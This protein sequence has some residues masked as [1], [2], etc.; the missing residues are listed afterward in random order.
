MVRRDADD[1]DRIASSRPALMPKPPPLEVLEEH[2]RHADRAEETAITVQALQSRFDA[3]VAED[4]LSLLMQS[5]DLTVELFAESRTALLS[6]ARASE[7]ASSGP[8]LTE[9]ELERHQRSQEPEDDAPPV[10]RELPPPSPTESRATTKTID[11]EEKG[12]VQ[13]ERSR[14]LQSASSEKP[15]LDVDR[16]EEPAPRSSSST[17][18]LRQQEERTLR[19]KE[20]ELKTREELLTAR[21]RLLAAELDEV[22][23]ATEAFEA[24]RRFRNN[25]DS[26]LSDED[27]RNEEEA[28]RS[29][30]L[31]KEEAKP[32]ENRSDIGS[33]SQRPEE[34]LSGSTP[35][36]APVV[37]EEAHAEESELDRM[38][39]QLD[40]LRSERQQREMKTS[41]NA[42]AKGKDSPPPKTRDAQVNT[43][44]NSPTIERRQQTSPQPIRHADP[45]SIRFSNALEEQRL[46]QETVD[47]ILA[48]LLDDAVVRYPLFGAAV[49][50]LSAREAFVLYQTWN[51]RQNG[52][53][54]TGQ[55]E[56][57]LMHLVEGCAIRRFFSSEQSFPLVLMSRNQSNNGGQDTTSLQK[58][59]LTPDQLLE[60]AQSVWVQRQNSMGRGASQQLSGGQWGRD[61]TSPFNAQDFQA[62]E[63]AVER[64]VRDYLIFQ[65]LT[66]VLST[67]P[68]FAKA[69]QELPQMQRDAFVRSWLLR[70]VPSAA[71]DA[72]DASFRDSGRSL[73]RL[74]SPSVSRDHNIAVETPQQAYYRRLAGNQNEDLALAGLRRAEELCHVM[75]SCFRNGLLK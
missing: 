9:A 58:L 64:F 32:Q 26:Q 67:F 59:R 44:S 15:Q 33:Q 57:L 23:Q 53:E 41:S 13:R 16:E 62:A 55:R 72:M 35:P 42:D 63:I 52:A 29:L 18:T 50:A 12:A 39:K 68:R 71:P 48:M 6:N 28:K 45:T 70:F 10:P 61:V 37:V 14:S 60:K 19:A 74:E 17:S 47:A 31:E 34:A 1:D 5:L 38:R 3:L 69:Y 49:T 36:S 56:Q 73:T 66:T 22:R 75:A 4:S 54:V 25:V 24:R 21:E 40:E 8:K 65:P 30:S 43:K 11:K 20:L 2:R 46:L 7:A 51:A 27:Q